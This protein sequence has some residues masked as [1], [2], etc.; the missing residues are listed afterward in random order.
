[1]KYGVMP[2]FMAKPH[3]TEAGCSG[4]THVSLRNK[5]GDNIFAVKEPRTDVKFDDLKWVSKECEHFLAGVLIGLPDVV[6]CLLPSRS[7]S[8]NATEIDNRADVNSY[9]RLVETYWAP[10]TVSWGYEV[11]LPFNFVSRQAR[12]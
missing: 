12:W 7:F 9:K 8:T 4:H 1:M 6:P 2:T 5:A 10:V 11:R 3:G